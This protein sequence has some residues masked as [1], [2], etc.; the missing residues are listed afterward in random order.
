MRIE[1][2]MMCEKLEMPANGLANIYGA[3]GDT[4]MVHHLPMEVQFVGRVAFLPDAKSH[5]ARMELHGPDMDPLTVTTGDFTYQPHPGL[6]SGWEAR[7]FVP[8]TFRISKPVEG[9]CT[10][11]LT[12]DDVSESIQVIFRLDPTVRTNWARGAGLGHT[13]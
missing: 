11:T 10:L 13:K 6:P 3:G 7:T 12:V 4:V 2:L 1:W 9:L 8:I 5:R